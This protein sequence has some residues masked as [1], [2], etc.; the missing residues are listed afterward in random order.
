MKYKIKPSGDGVTYELTF[1]IESEEDH[2]TLHDLVAIK[3][4]ES[5]DFI[6]DVYRAGRGN[7]NHCEGQI[8]LS[9]N[10]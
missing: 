1:T 7:T 9:D 10:K 5:G 4:A 2:I 3:I 8:I 6:G